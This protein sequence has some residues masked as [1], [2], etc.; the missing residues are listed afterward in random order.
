MSQAS[1]PPRRPVMSDG[2]RPTGTVAFLFTDIEGSTKRWE[3]HGPAMAA[4]V[5]RHDELLRGEIERRSGYVFKTVGDAFCAAFPT[6]PHAVAAALAGQ[7]ALEIEPW[8]ATGPI[9]ARMAVH[10]GA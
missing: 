8:G 5:A 10:V 7:R 9:R 2:T 1:P 6:V 4:A 3:A